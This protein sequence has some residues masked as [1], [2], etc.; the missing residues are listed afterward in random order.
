MLLPILERYVGFNPIMKNG[1][2]K[3]CFFR[4]KNGKRLGCEMKF[5]LPEQLEEL[6]RYIYEETGIKLQETYSQ[7]LESE[8]EA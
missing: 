5:Y 8:K 2:S 3:E 6:F 4:L 1:D 7:D